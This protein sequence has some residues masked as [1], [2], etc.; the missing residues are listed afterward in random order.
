M[1]VFL[2]LP[3]GGEAIYRRVEEAEAGEAL[4]TVLHDRLCAARGQHGGGGHHRTAPEAR[5][6][7]EGHAGLENHSTGINFLEG[8]WLLQK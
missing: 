7:G 4:C 1:C 6:A 3:A 2:L 8:L 5:R